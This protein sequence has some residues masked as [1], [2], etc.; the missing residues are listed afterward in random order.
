VVVMLANLAPHKGQ[1]TALR[2]VETLKQR[3]KAV[4]CWLVGEDRSTSQAFESELRRLCQELQLEDR[5]RFLGFRSD[6]PDILRAADVFL[7]PSTHEGLPL[8]LVEAQATQVPVIASPIPGVLEVVE[9]G[10]TGFTID[11]NDHV[12]YADCIQTLM[13][14]PGLRAEVRHAAADTVRRTYGWGRLES[15]MF[16]IYGKLMGRT[17]PGVQT[18]TATA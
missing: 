13:E 16:D 14:N 12:G 17:L 4:E 9:H 18:Q 1:M 15:S 10:K 8:S 7:L 11:A 2:A 6:A 5:V 3:G